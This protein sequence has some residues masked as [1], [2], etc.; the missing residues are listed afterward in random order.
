MKMYLSMALH[1]FYW[2]FVAFW[3]SWS[4]TQSA[5][6]LGRG[7]SPSQSRYLHMTTQTEQTHTD[8]HA[9]SGIRAHDPSVR[10]GEDG[11]CLRPRGHCDRQW[12]D[13]GKG[14]IDPCILNLDPSW[15]W[16]VSLMPRPLYPRGKSPGYP[17]DMRLGGPQNRSGQRGEEKNLAP[18]GA[19]TPTPLVV[20]VLVNS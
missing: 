4:F 8:I 16:V 13:M 18:T 5:G 10:E 3:V 19:R 11:S 15:R 7:I 14:F 17:L 12:R 2:A 1:P 20:G 6:L 9:S